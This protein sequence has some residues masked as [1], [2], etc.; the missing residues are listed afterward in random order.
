MGNHGTRLVM[1]TYTVSITET[2]GA[3]T[4]NDVLYAGDDYEAA[5]TAAVNARSVM[6]YRGKWVRFADDNLGVVKWAQ[7]S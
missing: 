1:T 7:I 2:R 4:N 5:F 3:S 6:G